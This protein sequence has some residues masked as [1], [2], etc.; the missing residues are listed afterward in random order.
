MF[1]AGYIPFS[2]HEQFGDFWSCLD[3]FRNATTY[4]ILKKT[5]TKEK[6]LPGATQQAHLPAQ[7]SHRSR[8]LLDLAR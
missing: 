4:R 5:E 7:P 2:G 8:E 6:V 1:P 3:I